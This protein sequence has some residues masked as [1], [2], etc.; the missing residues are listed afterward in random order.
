MFPLLT[1]ADQLAQQERETALSAQLPQTEEQMSELASHIRKVWEKNKRA[2]DTIAKEMLEALRARNGEYAPDKL[3]AIRQ[4]RS[5]EVYIKLVNTK[6][7]SGEAWLRDILFQSGQK[8]WEIQ[9]TPKP[10]LPAEIESDL[11][12][13]FYKE[14]IYQLLMNAMATGEPVD[15][16][17]LMEQ[18]YEL[19][20][21]FENKLQ[22]L[23]SEKAKEA[24]KEM[25]A[26]IN[27]DL[28]EGGFYEAL[29][30]CLYDIVVF[31][32]AILKGPIPRKERVRNLK[33]DPETGVMSVVLEEKNINQYERTSPFDIFPAKDSG[34][35]NDGDLI[36]RTFYR[37]DQLSGMLDL[38]NFKHDAIREI[39]RDYEEGK[40]SDWETSVDFERAIQE[41][42]QKDGDIRTDTTKIPCL[43]WWGAVQGK[44]LSEYGIIEDAMGQPLD[45]DRFYHAVAWLIHNQVIK[46]M[47]NK[48]P[49]GCKPYSKASVEMLPGSF[50]G[51]S[52]AELI[53]DLQNVVNATARA[54]VNNVG[55]ASGPQVEVC[56]DRFPE[57]YD[58]TLWAWKI[59]VSEE[60]QMS[61]KPAVNFFQPPMVTDK[62]INVLN[63]VFKIADEHSGIPAYAHGDPNVSGAGNT[64]SGLSMLLGG[65]ARGVKDIIKHIDLYLIAPTVTRQFFW[66]IEN[67]PR[68]GIIGDLKVV[69]MGSTYLGTKEQ[70][71]MRVM[72]FVRATTND[73]DL[74]IEGIEGRRYLLRQGAQ[75]LNIDPE[76]AFP[77]QTVQLPPPPGNAPPGQ[78][79]PG[80]TTLGP[81]GEPAQGQDFRMFNEGK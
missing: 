4:I 19:A 46:A 66:K 13:K 43:I 65:A 30:K 48:D 24:A 1:T 55:V 6:C 33:T 68:R 29:D 45:P 79:A 36:E 69:P 51:R 10:E 70:E 61:D 25:S 31:K 26:E 12:Q 44:K 53:L 39:L 5:S 20:P 67:K 42:Q 16:T 74:S 60:S 28:V 76:K 35:I 63:T 52:T 9:P 77:E 49:N 3:A 71:A 59:W 21:V 37:P 58:F 32:A 40:L 41:K 72:D 2:K 8:C 11:R 75:A 34:D 50:W 27:D 81:G 64:A 7:R 23:I 78:N 14:A 62:L 56:K 80:P 22:A 17:T 54:I 18:V 47:I 73:V 15:S 57:D 38:P